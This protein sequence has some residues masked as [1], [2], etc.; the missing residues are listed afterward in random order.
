M[1]VPVGKPL[2]S[3]CGG[4]AAGAPAVSLRGDGWEAGGRWWAPKVVLTL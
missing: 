1:L 3:E 2:F 4:V